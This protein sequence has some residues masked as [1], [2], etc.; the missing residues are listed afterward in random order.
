V[1]A[2]PTHPSPERWSLFVLELLPDSE[3]TALESHLKGCDAC[4]MI[5][6]DERA[7]LE[8]A[9]GD[10]P[11]HIPAEVIARWESSLRELGNLERGLYARHLD[12][13]TQCAGILRRLGRD[14]DLVRAAAP[15]LS[16]VE[17]AHRRPAQSRAARRIAAV[18]AIAA[19]LAVIALFG[20]QLF[21]PRQSGPGAPQIARGPERPQPSPPEGSAPVTPSPRAPG[22]AAPG[23][24][25][26]MRDST[27]APW[28]VPPK[29]DSPTPDSPTSPIA[30]P[31]ALAG[32]VPVLLR[33]TDDGPTPPP[34][35]SDAVG[36]AVAAAPGLDL[37]RGEETVSDR[38]V[39]RAALSGTPARA[40]N[41][42]VPSPGGPRGAITWELVDRY[43]GER[44]TT[45]SANLDSAQASSAMSRMSR[46]VA[47]AISHAPWAG[48]V[49]TADAS[50]V[51]IESAGAAP[52]PVGAVL[53]L[54]ARGRERVD[55]V[56]QVVEGYEWVRV[57]RA[58]VVTIE[59]GQ[60]VASP[61]DL[62]KGTKALKD[63]TLARVQGPQ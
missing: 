1:N 51:V 7:A 40:S 6:D 50:R 44:V 61:F 22:V 59:D 11:G 42:G 35:L 15:A 37:A 63:A 39:V 41:A 38:F 48:R 10:A 2:H 9:P 57:A 34:A 54:F 33:P 16:R 36:R 56:T 4:R 13:C 12:T 14:P 18:F 43:T 17:I 27:P 19:V 46:Q 23:V 49:R 29:P 62:E 32:G 53:E 45:R 60:I 31:S 26:A 30:P 28:P 21:A 5:V 52:P 25:P 3:Q 20:P 55:A 24:L 8:P 47:D 58:R